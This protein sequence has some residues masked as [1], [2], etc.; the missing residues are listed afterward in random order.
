MLGAHRYAATRF[1]FPH[2]DVRPVTI[3]AGARMRAWYDIRGM[4]LSRDQDEAGIE[5][6][7]RKVRALI[8]RE[9]Q[10]GIPADRIVLAGFSQ[11]GATA[12]HVAM[13]CEERL[14]GLM[15]LSAYLLFPGRLEAERHAANEG[16]PV[17]IGH[18]SMDP[19][20]PMALGQDLAERL[21]ALSYPVTWKQYPIPHS[22][23]QEEIADI[24]HWLADRLA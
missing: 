4:Q 2:A 11:G 21:R 1:V 16:L 13:R 19:M 20:V 3:N 12:V 6:S 18:G 14:A 15:A 9:N 7:A 5:Q 8:R 10:R 24:G 22:V 23:S 17:F